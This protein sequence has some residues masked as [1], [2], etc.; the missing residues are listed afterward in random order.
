MDCL[1]QVSRELIDNIIKGLSMQKLRTIISQLI[2]FQLFISCG[3]NSVDVKKRSDKKS[4]SGTDSYT[5]EGE[6]L[7]GK[8]MNLLIP[9]AYAM[10]K[11]LAVAKG[12]TDGLEAQVNELVS[13]HPE[14]KMIKDF[15]ETQCDGLENK[16]SFNS[17][18]K[19]KEGNHQ[20]CALLRAVTDQ[21]WD[22]DFTCGVILSNEDLAF[23]FNLTISQKEAFANS[24]LEV[25]LVSSQYSINREEL[26]SVQE[27][28]PEI[29]AEL[30]AIDSYL[31]SCG[32][33]CGEAVGSLAVTKGKIDGLEAKV[34]E[35]D[36]TR[37]TTISGKVYSKDDINKKISIG[38]AELMAYYSYNR[39]EKISEVHNDP[40]MS[41]LAKFFTYDKVL[42]IGQ[43]A[44]GAGWFGDAD[45]GSWDYTELTNFYDN[46]KQVNLDIFE[47]GHGWVFLSLGRFYKGANYFQY[48]KR[49]YSD[50]VD[51]FSA[52]R[53][54]YEDMLISQILYEEAIEATAPVIP[55]QTI[56]AGLNS[57]SSDI[58]HEL[59]LKYLR[60]EIYLKHA[61][62]RGFNME[63][64]QALVDLRDA[65]KVDAQEKITSILSDSYQTT[66]CD[67]ESSEIC[68]EAFKQELA[69]SIGQEYISHFNIADPYIYVPDDL[70]DLYPPEED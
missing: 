14:V 57:L 8:L 38:Q 30:M 6:F 70:R 29:R 68:V 3:V 52:E 18:P 42:I 39:Q 17:C 25:V 62:A 65:I 31:D 13:R 27:D 28:L 9:S 36:A 20:K 60:V 11:E 58:D 63:S 46:N 22:S 41:A 64:L 49:L 43:H 59:L 44:L 26:A 19:D 12:R 7:I 23:K 34:G 24:K 51:V 33:A 53:K 32:E 37:L 16:I 54:R 2:I 67:W 55:V 5:I 50:E 45:S 1:A 61:Q 69:M 66:S 15:K 4:K 47:P 21:M 40:W 10:G 35:L 48:Y 56:L